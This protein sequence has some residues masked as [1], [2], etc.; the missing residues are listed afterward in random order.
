M[1]KLDKSEAHDILNKATSQTRRIMMKKQ[2]VMAIIAALILAPALSQ[3]AQFAVVGPR[4]LGMGGAS[5]AAVNDSTAVYWN[6]A[7]LAQFQKVDIRIPAGLALHDHVGL[8]DTWNEINAIYNAGIYDA[9]TAARLNQ[10]LT[11]LDKPETG[12]DVDAHAGLLASIPLGKIAIGFSALS[13]G[14]AGMYPTIDTYHNDTGVPPTVPLESIALNNSA[15]TGISLVSAEPGVAL[16]LSLGDKLFIGANAKMMSVKT[17]VNSEYMRTGDFSNFINNLDASE[18]SSSEGSIDAG[19]MLAP[20]DRFSIGVVGR[21]LNSPTFPVKGY[22]AVKVP[23]G[24]RYDV[25]AQFGSGEIELEP[26]Y[27]A[28]AAIRLSKQ[29]TVTADYDLSKNKTLTPGYEDQTAA[30]GI[31]ICLPK[32]IV[33]LRGGLYKNTADKD[34]NL[35]YTAGV[36]VRIFAFRVDVAGAYDFNEREYQASVDLAAR[37]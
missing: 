32:E 16:A 24:G 21:Y 35:T 9:T 15:V 20:S 33:S 29:I 36:G 25:T 14:Y 26:Q 22:R 17:Y 1:L 5:V 13:I 23:S 6:P 27:R 18:T 28:G 7:A 2:I 31:E 3:A 8:R 30:A 11:D 37:F 4:A 19:I 10:L 34:S 12:A